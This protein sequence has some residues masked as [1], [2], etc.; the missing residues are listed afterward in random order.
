MAYHF[1]PGEP[2]GTALK[3]IAVEEIER[4]LE[5]LSAGDDGLDDRVHEARKHLK[6]LRALFALARGSL[7]HASLRKNVRAVRH[8]AHALAELRGEAALIECFEALRKW[9]GDR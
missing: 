2:S 4:T 7:D 1:E 9:S 5:T 6:K 3:R 8:A